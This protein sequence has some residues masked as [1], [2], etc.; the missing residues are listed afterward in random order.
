[1]NDKPRPV[2]FP[3]PG[4]RRAGKRRILVTGAHRR[5]AIELIERLLEHEL[6][7]LITVPP[8][9]HVRLPETERAV[10]EQ[11]GE[12]ALVVDPDV[13]RPV[14]VDADVGGLG[15]LLEMSTQS[16]R[17]AENSTTAS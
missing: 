13:P 2:A 6:V 3:D 8:A 9:V 16:R 14:A 15:Q 4:T 5:V 10:G 11:T 12:Q 1:M 17:H 7:E